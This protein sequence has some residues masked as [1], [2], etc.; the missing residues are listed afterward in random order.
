MAQDVVE[1]KNIGVGIEMIRLRNFGI[2]FGHRT[3]IDNANLA[4][5]GSMLTALIGRNGAGKSTLLRAIAGLNTDYQGEIEICGHNLR[6]ASPMTIAKS[7]SYVS[8]GRQRISAMR[9]SDIVAMGRAPYTNWIGRLSEADKAAV[10]DA[11]ADVGMT[12]YSQRQIDTLS[13]GEYQRIMIARALAQDTPVLLLDEPTSFLDIPN[14]YAL[15]RLLAD[16]AHKRNKC[17]VFSTHEL[18]IAVKLVDSLAVINPPG[19]EFGS[20]GQ[21]VDSGVIS[22][23]FEV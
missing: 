16:L 9:C 21:V 4:V 20:V 10:A 17:I 15:C 6:T 19:V 22:R 14:R 2:G 1:N 13:D 11:I 3:L 23:L 7:L 18:D 12:E 8:T 5:R